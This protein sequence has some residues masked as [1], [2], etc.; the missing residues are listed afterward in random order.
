MPYPQKILNFMGY[1]QIAEQHR[2]N[3]HGQQLD[4]TRNLDE[5]PTIARLR[6]GIIRTN[7]YRRN[8]GP[9]QAIDVGTVLMRLV[10]QIR[11]LGFLNLLPG[12]VVFK[13]NKEHR[14][15]QEDQ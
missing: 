6:P 12:L 15:D 2:S 7:G 9:I 10:Q 1:N 3:A 4:D 5:Y 11:P 13:I 8:Q 14:K